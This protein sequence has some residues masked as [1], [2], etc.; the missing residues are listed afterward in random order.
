MYDF[1]LQIDLASVNRKK[2]FTEV[3][4]EEEKLCIEEFDEIEDGRMAPSFINTHLG[5]TFNDPQG[6]TVQNEE[7]VKAFLKS[8]AL[9]ELSK[10]RPVA[11]VFFRFSHRDSKT[12]KFLKVEE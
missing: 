10:A 5:A 2:N 12:N 7:N 9:D 1:F 4:D 3:E 8:Q 6:G 11:T